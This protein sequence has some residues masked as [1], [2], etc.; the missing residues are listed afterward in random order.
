MGFVTLHLHFPFLS[1]LKFVCWVH[2]VYP[3]TSHANFHLPLSLC[4]LLLSVFL[5]PLLSLSTHPSLSETL[6]GERCSRPCCHHL[7]FFLAVGGAGIIS[8]VDAYFQVGCSPQAAWPPSKSP[9][10]AAVTCINGQL[11]SWRLWRDGGRTLPSHRLL[12]KGARLGGGQLNARDSG[13]QPFW[14]RVIA[15]ETEEREI[16]VGFEEASVN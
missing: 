4:S 9:A 14:M 13:R 7:V 5:S 1:W 8:H 12:I 6:Q 16:T 15:C 11:W 3:G 2:S 10:T